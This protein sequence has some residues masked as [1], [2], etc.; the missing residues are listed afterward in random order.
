MAEFAANKNA[1]D[2]EKRVK[3]FFECLKN[4][5][6]SSDSDFEKLPKTVFMI[7]ILYLE[8]HEIANLQRLNR[9]MF[10]T[11]TDPTSTLSTSVW[12]SACKRKFGDEELTEKGVEEH[13]IMKKDLCYFERK[14]ND[15]YL[16]LKYASELKW[17]PE[18]SA[19]GVTFTNENKNFKSENSGWCMIQTLEP[20]TR[21]VHLIELYTV[22]M[23]QNHFAFV[24]IHNKKPLDNKLICVY[25]ED[26]NSCTAGYGARGPGRIGEESDKTNPKWKQDQTVS[27]LVDLVLNRMAYFVEGKFTG[28]KFDLNHMVK[29][30]PE[31]YFFVSVASFT[32]MNITNHIVGKYN[33]EKYIQKKWD[34]S[35]S[36]DLIYD[37]FKN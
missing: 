8:L 35:F 33:I 4:T 11:L 31:L 21:A 16:F 1:F 3:E 9:Y 24:G 32:S 6:A 25:H 5:K 26:G 18:T 19:K 29:T 22:T 14:L 7:I 13:K 30:F 37:K 15:Y 20:L 36:L 10:K 34:N 28:W 23:D 27:I 2:S 12:K 17:D